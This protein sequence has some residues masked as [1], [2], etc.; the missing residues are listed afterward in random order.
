[1]AEAWWREQLAAGGKLDRRGADSIH[2]EP[3]IVNTTPLTKV[4]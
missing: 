4:G 3:T 2:A 1:V